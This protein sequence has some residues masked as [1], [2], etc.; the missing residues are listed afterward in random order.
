MPVQ[1]YSNCYGLRQSADRYV[2]KKLNHDGYSQN[3]E[4]A[5]DV[6]SMNF[7]K[8]FDKLNHSQTSK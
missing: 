2:T 5:E 1:L 8:S 4:R 6:S 3:D 7:S